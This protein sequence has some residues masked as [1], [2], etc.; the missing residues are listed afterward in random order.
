MNFVNLAL[1]LTAS[2]TS[3]LGQYLLKA[4]TLSHGSIQGGSF[5]A[6]M[7]QMMNLLFIPQ[8]L[9][10]ISAYGIGLLAYFIALSRIPISIVS[11]SLAL[12]YVLTVIMGK[13]VFN[14][15]IPIT[16]YFGVV[17]VVAGVM[18]VIKEK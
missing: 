6:I 14:E 4:A 8:V 9:A 11:P 18:L 1:I 16:R 2:L 7:T 12:A 13:V 5:L 15:V 10:G 3:V 17:L